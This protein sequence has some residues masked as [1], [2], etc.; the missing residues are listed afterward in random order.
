MAF[1]LLAP[2]FLLRFGLLALL[3]RNAV[4]RAAHFPSQFQQNQLAYWVYQAA[5]AA[6]L[7]SLFFLRIALTPP[8]LFYSGVVLYFIGSVLLAISVVNFAAPSGS[9]I[10][11][12]GLYRFSRNPMYLA[13]FVFFYGCALLTQSLLLF[14]FTVIFQVSSHWLI[15]S[16]ERWCIAQFGDEYLEYMKRVRRYL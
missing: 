12:N 3:D 16:E 4:A 8:F 5:N 9:G 13:Y 6:I 14:A 11:R 7:V 10:N 2:F 1:W 15:R